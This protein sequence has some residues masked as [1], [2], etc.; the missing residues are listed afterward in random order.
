MAATNRLRFDGVVCDADPP[1]L[2]AA[3]TDGTGT[4]ITFPAALSYGGGQ[5]VPTIAD[6]DYLPL[7]IDPDSDVLEIVWLTAYTSGATSG[8]LLRA[9]EGTAGVAHSDD[10]PL[11]HGPTTFDAPRL[12]GDRYIRSWSAVPPIT[13][14][15]ASFDDVTGI[16][17]GLEHDAGWASYV[18]DVVGLLDDAGD[19]AV[20]VELSLSGSPTTGGVG[21]SVVGPGDAPSSL[22]GFSAA[23]VADAIFPVVASF[24]ASYSPAGNLTV[25][26]ANSTD[27]DIDVTSGRLYILRLA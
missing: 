24:V 9:Q 26:L 1:A 4:A 12:A 13:V 11:V 10:A 3:L 15:A 19:Y 20:S 8:T 16:F 22:H 5:A 27:V 18:G 7:V 25:H 23:H 14:A 2:G 17:D 6:P 21:V